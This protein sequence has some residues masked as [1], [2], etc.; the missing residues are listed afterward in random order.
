MLS[1]GDQNSG[2]FLYKF[3][4]QLCKLLHSWNSGSSGETVFIF[5]CCL[6]LSLNIRGESR[7]GQRGQPLS[8]FT[9]THTPTHTLTPC[10]CP[11]VCTANNW[12]VAPSTLFSSRFSVIVDASQLL[13]C[14]SCS[15]A[16]CS[17]L[18]YN[19]K[20]LLPVSPSSLYPSS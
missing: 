14:I 3:S 12:Y 15:T 19:L 7:G 13:C 16:S 17:V 18:P 10:Y 6:I 20:F 8:Q 1:P 11:C 2:L 4:S 9:Y 5:C